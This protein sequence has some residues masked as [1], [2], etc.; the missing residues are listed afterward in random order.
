MIREDLIRL[1]KNIDDNRAGK[2]YENFK[3]SA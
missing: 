1:F 2:D 3:H